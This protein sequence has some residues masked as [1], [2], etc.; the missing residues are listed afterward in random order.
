VDIKLKKKQRVWAVVVH[1]FNP[2][3]WEA[4]AGVSLSSKPA[5]STELVQIASIT[6][7]N[8]VSKQN[9]AKQ[10]KQTKNPHQN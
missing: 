10:N 2:S 3:I 9:K 5:W 8:P 1:T 4:E 7:R 6:Q